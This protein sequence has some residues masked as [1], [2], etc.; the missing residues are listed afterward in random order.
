MGLRGQC[1]DGLVDEKGKSPDFGT[2]RNQAYRVRAQVDVLM[3]GGSRAGRRKP[4]GTLLE[5]LGK[6]GGIT[7]GEL[8]RS[9]ANV[10][11]FA[12]N[13]SAFDKNTTAD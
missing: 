2:L 13:S 10:L 1:D 4:D 3:P 9:A 6:D 7:L 5:S 11:R 12:M 8:Q